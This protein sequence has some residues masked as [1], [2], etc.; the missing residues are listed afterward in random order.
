MVNEKSIK[1]LN[2]LIEINNDRIEGYDTALRETE[3]DDLKTLFSQLIQTSE[4]CKT[5]LR[6]EVLKLGGIPVAGSTTGGMLFSVWT[7][8]KSA[9]TRQDHKGVLD[10]CL[11][12]EDIAVDGYD[13]V[14]KTSPEDITTQQR[15]MLH[16]QLE[17][18]NNDRNKIRQVRDKL[19]NV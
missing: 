19:I 18:I 15:T 13:K 5:Q 1:L 14:L 12:S 8:I 10:S 4:E 7:E 17:L 6:N 9:L 2:G 3:E 16:T 11:H